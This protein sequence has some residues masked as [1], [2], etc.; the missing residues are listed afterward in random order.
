MT[1]LQRVLAALD[2]MGASPVA[3]LFANIAASTAPVV[4]QVGR[5]LVAGMR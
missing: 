3:G 2:A 1:T 4:E 5:R